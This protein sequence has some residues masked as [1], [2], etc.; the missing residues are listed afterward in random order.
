MGAREFAAHPYFVSYLFPAGLGAG[1]PSGSAAVAPVSGGVPCVPGQGRA[2]RRWRAGAPRC[3]PGTALL[4]G[5]GASP[6]APAV[7]SVMCR[8]L[9]SPGGWGKECGLGEV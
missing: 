1:A 7:K 4:T 5:G 2:G 8:G 6:F 9:S 3:G